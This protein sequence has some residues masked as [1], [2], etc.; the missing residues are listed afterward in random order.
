MDDPE[1]AECF[2][3][4]PCDGCY[5]NVHISNVAES[6]LNTESIKEKQQAEA[7]LF[8]LVMKHLR[9]Y[10]KQSKLAKSK[11]SFAMSNRAKIPNKGGKLPYHKY[12]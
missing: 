1:R 12:G 2:L 5:L 3:N 8:M 10:I 9:R 7:N 4:L 6:P 11:I